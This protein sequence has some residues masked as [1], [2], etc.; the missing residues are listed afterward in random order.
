MYK[1]RVKI[2]MGKASSLGLTMIL[3]FFT[4]V[5]ICGIL[6]AVYK[7]RFK[8]SIF[9]SSIYIEMRKSLKNR[10]I[11]KK[12]NPK[13]IN[14]KKSQIVHVFIE[15]LNIVKLYHWKTTSY[16]QHKA[17]DDLY[18]ELN[19]HLDK[20]VETMLGKD[21]SRVE[22]W[23]REIDVVQYKNTN[24]FKSRIH[25]YRDFLIKLNDYFDEKRDSDLMS[26]RDDIL[27]DLNQF[28]YLLTFK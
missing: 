21:G 17:T 14:S 6:N 2:T 18:A 15:L 1:Y 11:R 23:E 28:L 25:Q 7:N 16:A 27:G 20:F 4:L 10:T 9:I 13:K 22:Q 5:G 8:S 19:E 12:K 26:Q 3:N 24:D